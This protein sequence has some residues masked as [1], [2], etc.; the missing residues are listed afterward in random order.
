M[1]L[2][3]L[4]ENKCLES[5]DL[6]SDELKYGVIARFIP[7][8]SQLSRSERIDSFLF[9]LL[10]VL[11]KVLCKSIDCLFGAHLLEQ[12]PIRPCFIEPELK[13][14]QSVASF[15]VSYAIDVLLE[16][17]YKYRKFILEQLEF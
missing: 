8:Q 7:A 2:N 11:I 3:Y 10:G 6:L 14:E 4:T 15:K 1:T 13:L 16:I 9:P 17:L 12:E 5:L